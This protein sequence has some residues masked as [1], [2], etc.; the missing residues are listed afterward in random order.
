[1]FSRI[2]PFCCI[3]NRKENTFFL[4]LVRAGTVCLTRLQI[5]HRAFTDL[6]PS[7]VAP[8]EFSVGNNGRVLQTSHPV[9]DLRGQAED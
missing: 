6:G 9:Q 7:H 2:V 5:I 3:E 1:M 8:W 4:Q